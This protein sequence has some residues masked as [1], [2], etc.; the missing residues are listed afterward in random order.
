M[1]GV[2]AQTIDF[3]GVNAAGTPVIVTPA[4]A[5][6]SQ[7]ASV[8]PVA[9][10]A[11][12]AAASASAALNS[13]SDSTLTTGDDDDSTSSKK[14]KRNSVFGKRD[15]DCSAQPQGSGPVPSPDTPSAFLADSDLANMANSASTPAGYAL[16]FSNL[17]ASLSASNYMGL[18]TLNSYDTYT[19][20][21][22]CDAASGCVAFNGTF[23]LFFFPH[24]SR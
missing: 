7:T 1:L 20:Q 18:Y 24:D 14:I 10:Q 6:A 21:E 12:A 19:C 4:V 15:G 13:D 23:F 5:V 11:S 8:L 17:Q 2:S 16:V 3:D 9:A 22:H